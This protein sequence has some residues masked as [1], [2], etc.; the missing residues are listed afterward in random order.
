MAP[1][2]A[3]VAYMRL[4]PS[5]ST[6]ALVLAGRLSGSVQYALRRNRHMQLAAQLTPAQAPRLILLGFCTSPGS[7]YIVRLV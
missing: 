7:V 4:V 3:T 2:W 1:V 5:C 6:L